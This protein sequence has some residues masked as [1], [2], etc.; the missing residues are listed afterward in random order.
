[1]LDTLY[2]DSSSN[3]SL[4]L[5]SLTNIETLNFAESIFDSSSEVAFTNAS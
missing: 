1:M 3:I 4:M 2:D 5:S